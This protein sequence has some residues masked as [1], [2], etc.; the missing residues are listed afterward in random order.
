MPEPKDHYK[1]LELLA[2]LADYKGVSYE[3]GEIKDGRITKIKNVKI[4][5]IDL[6]KNS[7]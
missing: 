5:E 4:D 1:T 2:K 3:I 7:E 6:T